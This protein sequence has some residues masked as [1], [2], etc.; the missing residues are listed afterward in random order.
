MLSLV[1]DGAGGAGKNGPLIGASLNGV[2]GG[3]KNPNPG[4]PG[5]TKP[6]PIARRRKITRHYKD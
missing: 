1:G 6:R 3:P 2:I 4:G 5:S